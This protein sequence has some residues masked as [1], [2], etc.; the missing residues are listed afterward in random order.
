MLQRCECD[1]PKCDD[2][3]RIDHL[4][5]G[6][7]QRQA[8]RSLGGGWR[9]VVPGSILWVAEHRVGNEERIT[10]P[11]SAPQQVIEPSPRSVPREGDPRALCTKPP[12]RLADEHDVC[13]G[14]SIETGENA[15]STVHARTLTAALRRSDEFVECRASR[16]RWP[17]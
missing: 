13:T 6:T 17:A 2:E 16:V 15:R 12:G 8:V 4:D 9:S 7:Q 11:A 14:R 1:G 10:R 5:L 3:Y